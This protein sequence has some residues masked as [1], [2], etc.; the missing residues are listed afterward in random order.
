MP[1]VRLC[2]LDEL[3]PGSAR[4]FDPDG[5]GADTV[6]LVRRADS[7]HAFVNVCPHQGAALEYRKDGFLTRD[8]RQLMCHAHGALFDP[9]TGRCTAGAGLGQSLQMLR[10][11]QQDDS[12]FVEI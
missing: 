10:C 12:V 9:Q 5:S 1:A 7:L 8:G 6:I 2:R 4:G 3:P 11:W